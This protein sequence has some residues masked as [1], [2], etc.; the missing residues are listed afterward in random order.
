MAGEAEVRRRHRE[1]VCEAVGGWPEP[2]DWLDQT[3]SWI[4]HLATPEESVRAA[5]NFLAFV[6]R[7]D[8]TGESSAPHCIHGVGTKP[9]GCCKA[10][11]D[12]QKAPCHVG[13][14]V[15]ADHPSLWRTRDR[16]RVLVTQPYRNDVPELRAWAARHGLRLDLRPGEGWHHPERCPLVEISRDRDG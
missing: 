8:V 1:A 6:E 10:V 9:S 7:W 13:G 11:T 15:E 3:Y 12:F 2:L 5:E 4:G 14:G 16:G